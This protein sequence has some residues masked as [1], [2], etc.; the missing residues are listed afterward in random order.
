MRKNKQTAG[1]HIKELAD[2][3]AVNCT[4]MPDNEMIKAVVIARTLIEATTK[5]TA[6]IHPGYPVDIFGSKSVVTVECY[7]DFFDAV[8]GGKDR[9]VS[10]GTLNILEHLQQLL[11]KKFLSLVRVDLLDRHPKN[12][13]APQSSYSCTTIIHWYWGR[14]Q[15]EER[16]QEVQQ[17]HTDIVAQVIDI[18]QR[19]GFKNIVIE[20]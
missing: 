8:H 12:L 2:L 15:S 20:P 5:V 16:R 7:G 10:S 18:L 9:R 14:I 3:Y 4:K 19:F 1:E 11:Y 13:T 6:W 17:N